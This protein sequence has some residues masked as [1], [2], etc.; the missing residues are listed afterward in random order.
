MGQWNVTDP[1]TNESLTISG[2]QE[3]T[4]QD[5]AEIFA[6]HRAG[7]QAQPQTPVPDVNAPA[8]LGG[9]AQNVGAN[10]GALAKGVASI[11]SALGSMQKQYGSPS[12]LLQ[13]DPLQYAGIMTAPIRSQLQRYAGYTPAADFFA[14]AGTAMDVMTGK[15]PIEQAKLSNIT[16]G[17]MYKEPVTTALD[18]LGAKQLLGALKPNALNLAR[19]ETLKQGAFPREVEKAFAQPAVEPRM[20]LSKSIGKNTYAGIW[21]VP[22]YK[23]TYGLDAPRTA[24][25]LIELG[26]KSPNSLDD[27]IGMADQVT[28][29]NGAINAIK[30][31]TIGAVGNAPVDTTSVV[32]SMS[33]RL[34]RIP[35]MTPEKAFQIADGYIRNL[36]PTGKIGTFNL[37][38]AFEVE[39]ELGDQARTY[40]GAYMQNKLPENKAMAEAFRFGQDEMK[41]QIDQAVKNVDKVSGE[42]AL[43]EQFK[44]PERMARLE[45]VSPILAQRVRDATTIAELQ[46]LERTFVNAMKLSQES[47]KQMT[48]P[49]ST[50]GQNVG[51]GLGGG[52]LG[53]GVGGFPGMITGSVLGPIMRP[54]LNTAAEALRTPIAT[55]VGTALYNLPNLGLENVV[56]GGIQG[57]GGM[58][59]QSPNI[60]NL[61]RI[62]GGG[63]NSPLLPMGTTSNAQQPLQTAQLPEQQFP[64]P[65][66]M[67]YSR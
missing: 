38:D 41:F 52:A 63:I 19:G 50:I 15:T 17:R 56:S 5:V 53:F 58:I 1:A 57:A 25:E 29:R 55:K 48:R 14:N 32:R 66:G 39:Q 45:S 16:G 65:E 44:T 8:S 12:E 61:L 18:F 35:E 51:Y 24:Q 21:N 3:P 22:K 34:L 6:Q 46:G 54:L 40:Q 49:L 43:L 11:P 42:Q 59:G 31:D 33:Q 47:L 2:D 7:G 67:M 30:M 23:G 20:P 37:M 13:K 27:M 26:V 64:A 10:V 4:Q 9:F 28:G 60:A 36:T 62:V